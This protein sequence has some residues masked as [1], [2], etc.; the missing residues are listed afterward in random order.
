M[1]RIDRLIHYLYVRRLFGPRCPT[2]DVDDFPEET[3]AARCPVCKEW[4]NYDALWNLGR[5]AK[6]V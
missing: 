1:N 2:L 3:H 5:H 4:E 6:V